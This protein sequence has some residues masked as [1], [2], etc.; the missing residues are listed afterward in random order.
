M[1]CGQTWRMLHYYSLYM[2]NYISN[3]GYSQRNTD[4][5]HDGT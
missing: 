5:Y 3:T 4:I 1:E 2:R